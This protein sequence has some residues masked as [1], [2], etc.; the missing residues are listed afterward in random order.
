MNS[1]A[2]PTHR[3]VAL[4]GGAGSGK[5]TL[6]EALLLRAG[7]ISRAG[8]VEQ[9][10]TVCDHEPEEIARGMTLGLS[11]A[12]LRWSDPDGVE[13]T[14]TLVDTPGHPDFVGGVD[15]ALAVADVALVAVSAVDGVTAGTRFVWAAAEAAGVPRIVVVTQ[16]DK[17]RADFRRV[18]GELQA[19]FGEGLWALELPLGEEQAF[20]G[21]ADVLSEQALEYDDEGRHHDGPMPADAEAE[22]H[23]MHVEVTEEIVSHDDDQLEAYLDGNEPS[24]PELERSFAREVATG[25]A[26][27]V[28]VCSAAT[29]T[30]VDRV[31]DL[32]CSLAPSSL[33]HDSRIV[34]GGSADG[35]GGTEHRVAPSADGETLLQVFRTVADPFVG[36]ISMFKVLSGV[37]RPSDRL[38]NA[39]TGA[40]ERIH[41]LFRLRGSEH[42]PVDALRAGEVGAVAKLT[43]SPSGSLLWTRTNGTA[44]P[45]PQ[46]RRE[47]V[48]AVSLAPATQSDDEKLMSSL[49]RLVAEDPTLV[50]DRTGGHTVLRG[51]GDTHVAVAVERLARVFG[52]HVTTSPAPV[53]YRETIAGNAQVEGKLKKQSG[54]HGQFAV[55]QLRVS[56]LPPGGGFEFVDSVVGGSVPRTYIPAV[57]KGA[58]DALAA[59]GPQGHPVVDVKVELFDGKS[60]SVDSSE[61]AFR[62]A[63][64]IGVKAALAEAGTVMLEPLSIVTV[65]VPADLQGTVLTDLSGRRGRVHATETTEDGRARVVANVPEAELGQYVL[66]LRS[67]TGGRAEL[68]IAPDRYARVPN[69]VKA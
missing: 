43:G 63:A 49:A 7:E 26:V 14:I 58:R 25:E 12:L 29:G 57:E 11:L 13:H 52:V 16:E 34:V 39:T 61:M 15:T 69:P 50:I 41:G 44:R 27:P 22:E 6:A 19:A 24:A 45:T 33:E 62:T 30:G 48:F 40:D 35:E 37:V 51:L 47:P 42:L 32:L 59:G 2:T 17:A 67:M 36:Q 1:A 9:G 5:T 38:H 28:V 64:S 53:A 68:T 23:R 10:N 60:H 8:T 20:H 55:V 31:A 56:P 4:I 18:L 54:G 66:D 65:T 3:T 46:P 21:I